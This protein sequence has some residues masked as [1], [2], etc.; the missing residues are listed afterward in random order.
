MDF[1]LLLQLFTNLKDACPLKLCIF[2]SHL[3]DSLIELLNVLHVYIHCFGA[4]KHRRDPWIP[5][6]VFHIQI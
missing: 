5:F 3:L 6:L 2:N 1:Q 4:G